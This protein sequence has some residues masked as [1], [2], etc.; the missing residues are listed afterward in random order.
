MDEFSINLIS[1]STPRFVEFMQDWI[2]TQKP[3]YMDIAFSAER[4][5]EDELDRESQSDVLTVV[6]SYV[7]M[8]AYIAIALG[9]IRSCDRLLVST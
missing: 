8:F 4:S 5:I 1:S 6:V 2:K 7:I 9:Q 3:E